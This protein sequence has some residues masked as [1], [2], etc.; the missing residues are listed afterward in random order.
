MKVVLIS[1]LLIFAFS[2]SAQE[3]IVPLVYNPTLRAI[4]KNASNKQNRTRIVKLD[5]LSL[6]FFDDFSST[7]V[8]PD[9]RKW[10]DNYAFINNTF[11][12]DQP[13]INVATLDGLDEF[14]MP[15]DFNGTN[16]ISDYLTSHAFD[17]S[18]LN[19]NSNVFLSF[20]VQPQGLGEK[21]DPRDSLIVEFLSLDSVWHRVWRTP[22][23][24]NRLFEQK[25][26]KVD[27]TK[28]FHKGFRFRFVN[29]SSLSGNLDHWHLDYIHFADNRSATD[30]I[31]NEFAYTVPPTSILNGFSAVPLTY[32]R[33]NPNIWAANHSVKFISKGFGAQTI[34]NAV[35]FSDNHGN[36]G[37]GK[38]NFVNT[39]APSST[40]TSIFLKPTIILPPITSKDLKLEA[41][42]YLGINAST[43]KSNDTIIKEYEFSDYFAYDDGT[44][45][46]G[47]GLN[48]IG[49]KLAYKFVNKSSDSIYGVKMYFSP[50]K[51]NVAGELFTIMVWKEIAEPNTTKSDILLYQSSFLKPYYTDSV[52]SFFVYKFPQA[53]SVTDSFY[54]GWQQLS[55]KILG[56]GLD[57]NTISNDKMFYNVNGSWQKSGIL[58]SWMIRPI[59]SDIVFG[60]PTKE[61]LSEKEI[62][63]FPNPSNGNFQITGLLKEN[64]KSFKLIDLAGREVPL[65]ENNLVFST[66]RNLQGVFFIEIISKS[67][68]LIHKKLVFY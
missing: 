5:T 32:L 63:I 64:I 59:M 38:V 40:T 48:T 35:D 68:N 1:I 55:D 44:A 21:P 50:I 62:Q 2:A 25:F 23:Q 20:F 19:I 34:E 15:Y 51:T 4:Y 16:G 11:T 14:G 3:E 56:I 29:Y 12:R 22:G 27:S 36:I 13:T 61:V 41:R 17:I 31:I 30:T 52:N 54:I 6:P 33:N 37:Y 43:I 49:G 39:V 26:I 47:Y 60:L 46:Y 7:S 9:T 58:G 45:E 67:G 28:F 53:I 57:R 10:T 8:Y 18:A 24:A 66:I 42:Y 65:I